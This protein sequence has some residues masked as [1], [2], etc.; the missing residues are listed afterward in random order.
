VIGVA[1]QER[2]QG[3]GEEAV[4]GPSDEHGV[5]IRASQ[6]SSWRPWRSTRK[7]AGGMVTIFLSSDRVIRSFKTEVPEQ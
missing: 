3:E 4:L 1:S 7:K 5:P 2:R 6:C